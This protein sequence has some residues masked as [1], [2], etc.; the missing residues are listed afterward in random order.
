MDPKWFA[1][2]VADSL[3]NNGSL[4]YN[5]SGGGG[6]GGGGYYYS[7][8]S[9]GSS[10]AM[11][12]SA[13]PLEALRPS[14]Q[15]ALIVLYSLTAII[16]FCSH[17]TVIMVLYYGK[18]SSRELKKFLINLSLSDVCMAL[19][20]I[21]FTYTHFMLGHWVFHP[22][23]CPLASMATITAL[24]VSV[25]TMIVIGID[26]YYAILHPLRHT[27]FVETKGV[28]ILALIWLVGALLAMPNMLTMRTTTFKY[29]SEILLDC[30]EEWGGSGGEIY[31]ITLLLV[32]FAL[33]LCGLIFIYGSIGY[34]ILTRK[35]VGESQQL[36]NTRSIASIKA[37]KM[38]SM[39]VI[40]FAICWTPI[41]MFNFVIWIFGD[42]LKTRTQFQ[43][44]I[45]VSSFFI[46]HWLAM[47]H[48]LVNPFIYCF[49]SDN[50]RSD[51]KYFCSQLKR[52]S[53]LRSSS[54]HKSSS[55]RYNNS[56]FGESY[57]PTGVE[58]IEL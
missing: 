46:C 14:L 15:W 40:L 41:Q 5:R 25:Y 35:P 2:K 11:D 16:A 8:G 22:F 3:L 32:T 37:I 29:N 58:S 44:N 12:S 30:R 51:L 53:L 19:C 31:S 33:P 57:A 18:K 26:R 36:A 54:S 38:M 45:Y 50:F 17:V 9:L 13:Y 34:T 20:S 23:L 55:M 1:D 7:N 24:C 43:M 27:G 49:M 10:S 28:L 4:A 21:P 39:V 6:A 52:R 48:S 56:K 47:A 42:S